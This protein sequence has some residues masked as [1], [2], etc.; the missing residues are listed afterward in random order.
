MATDAIHR[1]HRSHTESSTLADTAQ[2]AK[3][4]AA[5]SRLTKKLHNVEASIEN[6]SKIPEAKRSPAQNK[7]LTKLKQQYRSLL[8]KIKTL[9]SPWLVGSLTDFIHNSIRPPR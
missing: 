4:N 5:V 1:A 6:L 3:S 8:N 7:L 9:V 2:S